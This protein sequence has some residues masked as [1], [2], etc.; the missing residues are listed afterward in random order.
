MTNSVRIAILGNSFAARTQIPALRWAGGNEIVG[1]AGRDLEK[2]RATA[3]TFGIPKA[4]TDYRELL[5]LSPDLVLVSTPVHLHREM[6]LAALDVGAAVL[7]EKP[8]ALNQAEALE[9]ATRAEGRPAFLDHQLRWSP[10]LRALKEMCADGFLGEPWHLRFDMLLAPTRFHE[11]PWSWWFD[12]SRGGGILGA[13]GSHML[14]VVRWLFGEVETVHCELATFVP[15]RRDAQ[16]ALQPVTADDYAHLSLGFESGL[17]AELTTSIAIPSERDFYLQVTGSRGTLRLVD[18]DVLYAGA[19]GEELLPVEV[20][21]AL[22]TA[23]EFGMQEYGLFGRCLPLYL[24]DL[25]DVLRT[26]SR[27]LEHAADF[28]DGLAVQQILDAARASAAE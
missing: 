21:P 7:C 23:A 26:G 27:F 12:A 9:M 22:P 4:T 20:E 1:I 10:H 5:E 15:R 28:E 6:T 24:K 8:F 17:T 16:G 18:G 3:Q 14:D 13:I 25:L 19:S 11:R 2:A